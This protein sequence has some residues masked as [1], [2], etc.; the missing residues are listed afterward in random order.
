MTLAA[1]NQVLTVAQMVAA[2]ERLMAPEN[3]NATDVH[4]LMQRAGRG[5]A[6]YVWRMAAG[7]PEGHG[8]TVLCGPGNNGGD[9]YVIAE[10]IR[11]RGGQVQVVV[12]REPGTDAAR[13]AASLYRGPT[14]SADDARGWILVDCLFGSGLNRALSGEL[15]AMLAGLARRHHRAV[16]IDVPSGVNSDTGERLAANL[17]HYAMCIALGAWKRAHLLMP[18]MASW[19]M[20]RLVDIGAGREPGGAVRVERPRL[21]RPAADAHKYRRGLVAVIGG[22]MPGAAMLASRAAAHAGA[23]YVKLLARETSSAPDWLVA[24]ETGDG[25]LA[26][27]LAD[28]RIAALL[29]GPGLGRDDNA[30]A[31]LNAALA[32]GRRMVLDADALMLLDGPVPPGSILTPHEGE[33]AQLERHFGLDSAAA[34][35]ERASALARASGAVIVAKGPDTVIAAPDGALAFAGPASSWLS[36]AGTGDVLAGLCAA[37]LAVTRDPVRAAAEAVW[38]HAEA[39]RL[40]GPAFDAGQLA[41]AVRPALQSCL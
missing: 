30:R 38:L 41:E 21:S 11:E 3:P 26:A 9:G 24:S 18:A 34:K 15:D 36:V 17:P 32:S 10:A 5:A 13:R 16:A 8:V 27:A 4:A 7:A 2:E 35:P 40:A 19:D 14:T 20:A 31:R 29:A 37:R 28:D 12:A 1:A 33:L 39:A 22:A 6:D 23:G 25:D